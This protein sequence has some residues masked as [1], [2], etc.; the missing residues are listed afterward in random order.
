MALR[1]P[2]SPAI[3]GVLGVLGLGR[4]RPRHTRGCWPVMAPSVGVGRPTPTQPFPEATP[5]SPAQMEQLQGGAEGGSTDLPARC[6]CRLP[7][8]D[9]RGGLALG[10]DSDRRQRQCCSGSRKVGVRP[11]FSWCLT[12]SPAEV[13]SCLMP[14]SPLPRLFPRTPPFLAGITARDSRPLVAPGQKAG[15][16]LDHTSH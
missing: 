1:P 4:D 15:K 11:C 10:V 6:L 5:W 2:Q 8:T 12:N 9:T 16:L 7:A 3:G 13:T 14:L